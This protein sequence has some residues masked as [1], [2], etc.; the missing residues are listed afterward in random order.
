MKKSAT[1]LIFAAASFLCAC[2]NEK[3][4]EKVLLNEVISIHDHIMAKEDKLMHNKMQLDTLLM[5]GKGDST[6]TVVDKATMGAYRSKLTAADEAMETWMQK[7]DPE[8]K[9]KSHDEKMQYFANQKKIV[10]AID[11]QFTT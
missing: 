5:P 7:F 9:G 4:K 8:L 6:H 1:L 10:L 2:N 11:S 3:D